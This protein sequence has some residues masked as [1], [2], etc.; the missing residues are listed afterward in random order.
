MLKVKIDF[1]LRSIDGAFLVLIR[2]NRDLSEQIVELGLKD[3]DELVLVD[4]EV[5]GAYEIP[6]TLRFRYE[7]MLSK[8]AWVA[9]PT[10]TAQ[11]RR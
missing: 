2:E 11:V 3:G 7:V 6:A 10:P 1:N 4:L 9:V 8:N 5:D